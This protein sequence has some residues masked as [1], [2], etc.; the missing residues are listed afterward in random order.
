MKVKPESCF[1]GKEVAVNRTRYCSEE[2]ATKKLKPKKF[3][4]MRSPHLKT[5]NNHINKILIPALNLDMPLKSI[6]SNI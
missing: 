5:N 2:C 4:K 3:S 1:C 6:L